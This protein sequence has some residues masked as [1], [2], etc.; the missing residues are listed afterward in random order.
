MSVYYFLVTLENINN[1]LP[2]WKI[3]GAV[4]MYLS[5][6]VNLKTNTTC[7]GQEVPIRGL[8]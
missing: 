7:F 3:A 5:A 6:M 4:V 8:Y 2:I 1:R